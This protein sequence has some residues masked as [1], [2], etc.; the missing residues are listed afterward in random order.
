MAKPRAK[1]GG[2]SKVTR[3]R[4]WVREDLKNWSL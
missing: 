1:M 3:K 4:T 2:L